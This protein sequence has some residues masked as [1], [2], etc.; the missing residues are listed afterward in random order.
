M[1]GFS[2]KPLSTHSAEQRREKIRKW[3]ERFIKLKLSKPRGE[4]P[5]DETHGR[6]TP[7]RIWNMDQVFCNANL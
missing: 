3:F 1:C 7:D 5:L 6:F 2:S 4:E